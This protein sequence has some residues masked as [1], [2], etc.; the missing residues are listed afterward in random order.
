MS[1]DILQ[2]FLCPGLIGVT[3]DQLQIFLERFNGVC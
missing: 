2:I 1:K 3:G